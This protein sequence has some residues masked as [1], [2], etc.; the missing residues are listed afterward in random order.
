[1]RNMSLLNFSKT[2]WYFQHLVVVAVAVAIVSEQWT[3]LKGNLQFCNR[4]RK[5]HQCQNNPCYP[6]PFRSLWYMGVGQ[7]ACYA[8]VITAS[9][10]ASGSA[11]GYGSGDHPFCQTGWG[12]FWRTST[13]KSASPKL[14]ITRVFH[15][16]SSH[17]SS[18]QNSVQPFFTSSQLS[19][20]H[21]SA[22]VPGA[23]IKR[24]EDGS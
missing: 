16:Q 24:P 18:I 14:E 6:P 17:H 5:T 8:N 22:L 20:Q 13:S 1:M 7:Y 12:G 3:K 21:P 19:N 9:G 23:L 2:A 11:S 10:D 15:Q 4:A